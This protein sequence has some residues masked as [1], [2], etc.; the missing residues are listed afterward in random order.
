[1]YWRH[2]VALAGAVGVRVTR[3]DARRLQVLLQIYAT[4]VRDGAIG[5]L[6]TADT[7]I[8]MFRKSYGPAHRSDSLGPYRYKSQPLAA[9]QSTPEYPL[10]LCSEL[11]IDAYQWKKQDSVVTDCFHW[12]MTIKVADVV[13]EREISE[14]D[15]DLI[16]MDIARTEYNLYDYRLHEINEN[17]NYGWL[18]NMFYSIGQ[19]LMRLGVSG[20]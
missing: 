11:D 8:E 2:L 7:S 3:C 18:R 5:S 12:L 9:I 15:A 1:M 10:K 14:S 13:P 17:P 20:A 6:K 19:Q 16:I 4:T